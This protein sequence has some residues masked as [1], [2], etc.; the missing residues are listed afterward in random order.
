VPFKSAEDRRNYQ[1]SYQRKRKEGVKV[2]E[3]ETLEA[4]L[5][6]L[7]VL[8]A[9]CLAQKKRIWFLENQTES[10]RRQR[11]RRRSGMAQKAMVAMKKIDPENQPRKSIEL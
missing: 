6:E 8:R 9:Q 2:K 11:V 3:P 7:K 4:A 1:R 10:T 5:E